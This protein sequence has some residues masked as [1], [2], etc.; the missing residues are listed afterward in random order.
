MMYG[1]RGGYAMS[2]PRQMYASHT[3]SGLQ[4]IVYASAQHTERPLIYKGKPQVLVH[5]THTSAYGGVSTHSPLKASP[6]YA[7]IPHLYETRDTYVSSHSHNPTL[8]PSVFVPGVFLDPHR[9]RQR[10]INCDDDIRDH[11]EAVTVKNQHQ[12]AEKYPHNPC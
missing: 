12:N 2:T 4:S 11:I 10:F 6:S 1:S 5:D 9:P 7:A 3:N 8:S